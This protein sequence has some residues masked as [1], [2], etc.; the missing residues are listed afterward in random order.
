MIREIE[1]LH[2]L[3]SRSERF[4]LRVIRREINAVKLLNARNK[5]NSAYAQWPNLFRR[6]AT[7][8]SVAMSANWSRLS[9]IDSCVG[10]AERRKGAARFEINSRPIKTW[11]VFVAGRKNQIGKVILCGEQSFNTC[12][13]R[14]CE[15]A[16]FSRTVTFGIV[17]NRPCGRCVCESS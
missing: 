8:R 1:I 5:T 14:S 15:I 11:L 13:P 2:F 3:R 17:N 7:G 10:A 4:P 12:R 16:N 9:L 6:F